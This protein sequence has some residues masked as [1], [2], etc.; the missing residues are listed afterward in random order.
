ME[1]RSREGGAGRGGADGACL[2][3]RVKLTLMHPAEICFSS[4]LNNND[5]HI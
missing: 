2:H 1:G 5:H 4:Q 3:C